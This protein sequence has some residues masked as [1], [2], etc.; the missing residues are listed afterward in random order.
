MFLDFWGRVLFYYF[1]SPSFSRGGAENS[2]ENRSAV[3][4]CFGGRVLPGGDSHHEREV[5]NILRVSMNQRYFR[6][7]LVS[8]RTA[9]TLR[10]PYEDNSRHFFFSFCFDPSADGRFLAFVLSFLRLLPHIHTF[11]FLM[12]TLLPDSFFGRHL[13]IVT[14]RLLYPYAVM[15]HSLR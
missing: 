2:V 3:R 1:T 4:S 14:I 12:T 8:L 11:R 13:G 10:S 7:I 15:E 9:E 6:T 5:F